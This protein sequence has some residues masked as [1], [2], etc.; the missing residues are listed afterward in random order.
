M[1]VKQRLYVRY[2]I[3]ICKVFLRFIDGDVSLVIRFLFFFVTHKLL[4]FPQIKDLFFS[5]KP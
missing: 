3:V 4:L 5:E 2:N 1:V